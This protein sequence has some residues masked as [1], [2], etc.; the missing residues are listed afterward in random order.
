MSSHTWPHKTKSTSDRADTGRNS[1]ACRT[2]TPCNL[3]PLTHVHK[4][5]KNAPAAFHGLRAKNS[6]NTL[7]RYSPQDGPPDRNCESK[8]EWSNITLESM[9]QLSSARRLP[10]SAKLDQR[11]WQVLVRSW[12]DLGRSWPKSGRVGP[13]R[14][15]CWTNLGEFGSGRNGTTPDMLFGVMFEH[16]FC[17]FALSVRRPVRRG[18]HLASMLRVLCRAARRGSIFNALGTAPASFGVRSGG[19]SQA[20][21]LSS[22][23]RRAFV[24]PE[25]EHR[26]RWPPY[27]PS[28]R[29]VL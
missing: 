5:L 14:A 18:S 16:C 17:K 23:K 25:P 21:P 7:A 8:T 11:V 29:D 22:A 27:G 3:D 13:T 10:N 28:R 20:K 1:A 26:R 4:Q 2:P 15:Q 19:R 6:R 12:P 9:F 24:R